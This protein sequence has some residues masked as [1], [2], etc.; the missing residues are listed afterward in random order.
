VALELWAHGHGYLM[1]QRTGRIDLSQED[2]KKLV[3]RSMG[4]LLHGLKA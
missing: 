1:L 3:Q 4:R 2:F